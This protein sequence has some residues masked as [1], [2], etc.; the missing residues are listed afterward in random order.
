MK[1]PTKTTAAARSLAMVPLAAITAHPRNPRRDLGDLTELA[2]SIANSGL[3][4]PVILAPGP[5][6]TCPD[7]GTTQPTAG[8]VIV[9][10][11]TSEGMCPGGG[12]PPS[13]LWVLIAG[14]RRCAAAIQAELTEVPAVLR[15]DLT[16]D[17]DQ[18]MAM[19]TENLQRS[20][21]TPI[22][23]AVAYTQ[24]EILGVK[25]PQIAKTTGRSRKTIERRKHLMDLPE[26][27]RDRL[28]AHEMT[29]ADAEAMA[30]FAD[31]PKTIAK[32]EKAASTGQLK[33]ELQSA[34]RARE[35]AQGAEK[36]RKQLA[37]AGVRT[38]P[39][40]ELPASHRQLGS[41]YGALDMT[42]DEHASCPHHAALE[43]TSDYIQY[44]CLDPSVHASP[45]GEL[46]KRAEPQLD[47]E[48]RARRDAER[49]E[50]EQLQADLEIAAGLRGEHLR[51]FMS[52]QRALTSAQRDAVQRQ[53]LRLA[54]AGY[55]EL[56]AV[57]WLVR[58][59]LDVEDRIEGEDWG[60]RQER[61]E[62]ALLA[63]IERRD[64]TLMTLAAL[65]SSHEPAL[66]SPFHWQGE[67]LEQTARPWLDLLVDLGY[68]LSDFE[69]R[70][71][72]ATD[73]D[74]DEAEEASA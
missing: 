63:E 59:G 28:Q 54:A 70:M 53:M 44:V 58:A 49:A 45:S 38:V 19:L 23:E 40:G 51:G 1:T 46:P 22:E 20:D 2:D 55:V 14:H 36:A 56:E 64:P 52:G 73:I 10:H 9:E 57:L 26:K 5:A 16:G 29:L 41:H 47:P 68:E 35:R 65:A 4:E 31:D 27:T 60:D 8:D 74:Q 71:L 6:S 12:Q 25:V 69:Q 62:Q 61:L 7:C 13:D 30:E 24:L 32:L 37:G 18:V 50:R 33:W 42:P 17:A 34:K 39:S 3:L 21:L 15:G 48:E 67:D 11:T 66:T 43:P 72:T